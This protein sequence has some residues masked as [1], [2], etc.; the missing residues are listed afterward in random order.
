MGHAL[1][2]R[3]REA[4]ALAG[5]VLKKGLYLEEFM[6]F[7]TGFEKWFEEEKRKRESEQGKV[8]VFQMV[9]AFLDS[10]GCL[11]RALQSS[12]KMFNEKVIG[13][14]VSIE[15][16]LNKNKNDPNNDSEQSQSKLKQLI[17]QHNKTQSKL[18]IT[19]AE[20]ETLLKE[21]EDY[22]E[23]DR[24]SKMTLSEVK[25]ERDRLEKEIGFLKS[26]VSHFKVLHDNRE[27]KIATMNED[28]EVLLTK[29]KEAFNMST[30]LLI[31]INKLKEYF[32]STHRQ[33]ELLVKENEDLKMKIGTD[34]YDLTPRPNWSSIAKIVGN[35]SGVDSSFST[36]NN[37]VNLA[38]CFKIS[39][40]KGGSSKRSIVMKEYKKG[41]PN[42][43]KLQTTPQYSNPLA[44]A[45]AELI[46]QS[47][48][49]D[50]LETTLIPIHPPSEE[51]PQLQAT[52]ARTQTSKQ[53]LNLST[54]L[55][56]SPH[57]L[58]RRGSSSL[59]KTKESYPYLNPQEKQDS[60]KN[61]QNQQDRQERQ[62]FSS[63]SRSQQFHSV[64]AKQKTARFRSFKR[65]GS[66]NQEF[67]PKAD[68]DTPKEISP[69]IEEGPNL[70]CISIKE[71]SD[72]EKSDISATNQEVKKKYLNPADPILRDTLLKKDALDKDV[73]PIL[74][75]YDSF[76]QK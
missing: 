39:N 72:D 42:K 60:A 20:N 37:V 23:M 68:K 11:K 52:L 9:P 2:P 43:K 31:Q 49:Q 59:Q 27:A 73:Q 44:K 50:P 71:K 19:Q 40:I 22:K 74:A 12:E 25:I 21:K 1:G 70:E 35:A 67:R 13:R 26:E 29:Y 17:D 58:V 54:G 45:L 51:S 33:I 56:P 64:S 69:F 15:I 46:A 30:T 5:E 66:F 75:K 65:S 48:Q 32:E 18:K 53:N 34:F 36:L 3:D 47:T 62:D 6:V 41:Q 76:N 14:Y 8:L 63:S 28:F 38:S 61:Q 7:E 10:L 55:S 24:T 4:L 16:T 57:K